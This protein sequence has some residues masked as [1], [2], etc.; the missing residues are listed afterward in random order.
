MGDPA[1]AIR[2]FLETD[3]EAEARIDREAN[4]DFS[5]TPEEIRHWDDLQKL[6]SE[7]FNL[8]LAVEK[9][10]TQETV[11]YGSLT[12]PSFNYDPQWYWV[13]VGVARAHRSMGIGADLYD[14]LEG[15]VRARGGLGMW[16]TA[17]DGDGVGIPFL[18][19]RGFRVV[20]K[21]WQSRLDLAS[22]DLTGIL[23]RS[24]PADF[25][26]IRF[27][28]LA[29]EGATSPDIQRKIHQICELTGRDAPRPGR[30]HSFSF[31]E[32]VAMDIEGPGSI[33]E[34]LFLAW[35]GAELVGVST[36]E[37]DLGRPDTLR[38]GFTGTHPALRKRGIG[39]HLKR[40][41]IE[42]AREHNYRYLVTANNSLNQPIL[43]INRRF[44]FLPETTWAQCEKEFPPGTGP[45]DKVG[46]G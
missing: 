43:A 46:P 44:G 22:P 38:V 11:G 30:Y 18:E 34:G 33:A 39:T 7:H 29:E 3:Y 12:Q 2:P 21:H 26:G 20:Q 23:A 45:T 40:R 32:F 28:T 25:E 27:S 36:V 37:R 41:A 31:E 8:K 17:R 5:A 24:P 15:V 35:K 6:E 16:G 13:W 9:L 19:R 42:Y 10:D 14:R 4:P 1:Y